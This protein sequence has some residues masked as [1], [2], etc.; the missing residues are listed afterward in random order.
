MASISGLEDP[1]AVD[2]RPLPA[3]WT[4][5]RIEDLLEPNGLSYGIVQPGSE[6][7]DGVPILRVKNLRNGS[8]RADDVLRVSKS[9][10]DKYQRTRLCGGEVLLTL[11][12]SVGEVAVAPFSLAGWNV[13]RAVAVMRVTDEASASWIRICLSSELAQHS[14]NMWQTTTV[15][16]TLNLR[17]VRRL[18]IIMPPK[19]ERETITAVLGAIDDKIAVN[20]LI[21]ATSSS[22]ISMLYGHALAQSS[23][24][25]TSLVDVV[26]FDFGLPFSSKSFNSYQQG[27]PLLRIRDL[28][29]F[30]PQ[31][32]TTERLPKDIL[33]QP[34][35][36]VAGMDAE[37]RPAFWLGDAVLLNQR[38]LRGRSRITGGGNA[39]VREVLMRPFS[40]IERHKTG[41]T[42]IHLN[43]RD[44]DVCSVPVPGTDA[45]QIFEGKADPLRRR[46]VSASQESAMLDELR[47]VL[48][49]RLM[50]GEIRVRDADR[51]VEDAT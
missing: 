14:M 31:V 1:K 42:V 45:L 12:G 37:F 23:T 17:D 11:V 8:V 49:P 50:S 5:R 22:L 24:T 40:D 36:V 25:T 34:G 48:L 16:A 38:V 20:D 27:F 10:E 51:V 3:G 19:F 32:W 30:V 4:Y 39:F 44:I 47:D 13:A 29:T 46:L 33:V 6:D 18:P 35:D 41:T 9:V 15:Q 28:K 21:V 7:P 43:K 2:L 26:A